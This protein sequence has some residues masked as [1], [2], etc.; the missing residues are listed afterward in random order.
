MDIIILK[1]EEYVYTIVFMWNLVLQFLKFCSDSVKALFFI[2]NWM[3]IWWSKNLYFFGK[4]WTWGIIN[5][6]TFSMAALNSILLIYIRLSFSDDAV[7]VSQWSPL[8]TLYHVLCWLI[9]HFVSGSAFNLQF[10]MVFSVICHN[11][12]V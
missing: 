9:F 4:T 1:I 11:Y 3:Y 12:N 5:M 6:I 7:I 2:A 10:R 8:I